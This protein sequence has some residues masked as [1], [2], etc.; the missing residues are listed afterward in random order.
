MY[1]IEKKKNQR[2]DNWNTF[3][4][5]T[6][7]GQTHYILGKRLKKTAQSSLSKK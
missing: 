4:A 5:K 7:H 6:R 1:V 2:L 3:D